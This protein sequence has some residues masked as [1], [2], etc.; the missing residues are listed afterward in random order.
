[1]IFL[2]KKWK[3]EEK[4]KKLQTEFGQVEMRGAQLV[5]VALLAGVLK[6]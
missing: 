6:L 3:K 2:K 4:K 1:L 5:V